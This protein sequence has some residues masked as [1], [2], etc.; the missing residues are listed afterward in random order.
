MRPGLIQ[1]AAR[2]PAGPG[3]IAAIRPSATVTVASRAPSGVRIRPANS[4][5]VTARSYHGASG[6]TGPADRKIVA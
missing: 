6:L 4:C 5:A 3:S 1:A 2:P